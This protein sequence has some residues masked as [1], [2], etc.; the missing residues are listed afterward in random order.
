MKLIGLPAHEQ[1]VTVTSVSSIN[2]EVSELLKCWSM[3][4]MKKD[5]LEN[6]FCFLIRIPD[7]YLS[8]I[9]EGS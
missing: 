1:S 9:R 3:N 2:V 7:S 4:V 8:S 5:V 6:W